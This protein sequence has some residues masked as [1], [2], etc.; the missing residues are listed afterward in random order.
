VQQFLFTKSELNN[1]LY[2][3]DIVKTKNDS[4]IVNN[5]EI[6]DENNTLQGK[7]K[8]LRKTSFIVGALAAIEGV[9]LVLIIK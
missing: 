1:C 5:K 3:F 8:R 6:T 7:N 4:L 2:Q 9:I